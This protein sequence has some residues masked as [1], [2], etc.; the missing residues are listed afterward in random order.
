MVM[1]DIEEAEQRAI[2]ASTEAQ[3]LLDKALAWVGRGHE[4]NERARDA[5]LEA[6]SYLR[7]LDDA[8]GWQQQQG[9]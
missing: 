4:N 8:M 9:G 5:I 2:L 7:S 1:I 6:K 3:L